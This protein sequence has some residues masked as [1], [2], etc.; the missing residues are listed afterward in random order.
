MNYTYT[1]YILQKRYKFPINQCFK[2]FELSVL[3]VKHIYLI[4]KYSQHDFS[5]NWCFM[6]TLKRID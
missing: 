1:D 5:I 3:S 4:K 6:G 2:I